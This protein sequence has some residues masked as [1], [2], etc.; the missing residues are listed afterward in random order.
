[1][2]TDRKAK[3]LERRARLDAQLRDLDAREKERQRKLDTRRK[4]IAGA[5]V[6]EH[7]EIKADFAIELAALLNRYV[8]R[9]EDRALFDF[10][11]SRVPGVGPAASPDFAAA[12]RPP[13]EPSDRAV[14]AVLPA[15]DKP[16][17]PD[18]S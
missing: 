12:A 17:A 4:I 6:L 13:A 9:P 7:A 14:D 8:T 2:S 16:A 15:S 3:L 18:P 1:M 10:L 5:L 11:D